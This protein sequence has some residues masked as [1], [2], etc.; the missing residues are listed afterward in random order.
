M[1]LIK[2]LANHW[3]AITQEDTSYQYILKRS[4]SANKQLLSHFM[5]V[6]TS[7]W[8]WSTGAIGAS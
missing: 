2:G 4:K 3:V 1:L 5:N 6:S 7:Y 8:T